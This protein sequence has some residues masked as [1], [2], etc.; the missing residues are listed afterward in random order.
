MEPC[1]GGVCNLTLP[2]CAGLRLIGY[3]RSV[4]HTS[5]DVANQARGDPS[6][7]T[8]MEGTTFL[9]FMTF[10]DPIQ[11]GVAQAVEK[12]HKA[13]VR[14]I[15]GNWRPPQDWPRCCVSSGILDS[16]VSKE[17]KTLQ[18]SCVQIVCC[19][20]WQRR[21]SKSLSQK[22]VSSHEPLQMINS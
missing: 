2:F 11:E 21:K 19:N 17:E 22:L 7:S 8:A 16:Q 6:S 20:V 12:C 13:G 15:H 5:E 14:V 4:T 1:T 9:G 18:V 10:Q 3:V